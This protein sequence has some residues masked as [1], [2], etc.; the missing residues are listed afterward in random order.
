MV[1]LDTCALIYLTIDRGNLS[2]NA[3][4]HIA[5]ADRIVI[6]SI[7]IWEVGLKHKKGKLELPFSFQNYV[8]NVYRISNFEFHA[9]D[10]PM[11]MRNIELEWDHPDPADRTIVA[12]AQLHDC[13]L[14]TS[15]RNILD[16]YP[17]AVW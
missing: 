5:Q 14:I 9:V 6:S 7:S 2:S 1:V 17:L 3:V 10:V 8:D 15:D 11:W 13:A 4:L 16:F 12:T